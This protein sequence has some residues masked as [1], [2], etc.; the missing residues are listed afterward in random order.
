MSSL[1]SSI[2]STACFLVSLLVDNR[3]ASLVLLCMGWMLLGI[4]IAKIGQ[5]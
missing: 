5:S 2:I 1:T 4:A 3:A